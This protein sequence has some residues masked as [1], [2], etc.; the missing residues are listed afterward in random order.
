MVEANTILINTYYTVS[1]HQVTDQDIKATTNEEKR[2]VYIPVAVNQAY[3][4]TNVVF[5]VDI[6]N[7]NSTNRMSSVGS[8]IRTLKRVIPNGVRTLIVS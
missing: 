5:N 4:L 6:I 2:N 7:K 8:I 1:P 3:S